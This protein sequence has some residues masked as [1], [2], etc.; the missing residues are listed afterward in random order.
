MPAASG[1]PPGAE[2]NA[3]GF[4]LRN[5]DTVVFY[6][7]SITEQNYYNQYVELYA[8]TRFPWMRIHFYGA[9]VG[10]DRVTGGGGG[11]VD[12]R[13]E[14]DVFSE[15]PT[16]VTVMLGMNDG[17]YRATTDEI[18]QT[19]VKGYEH[20]LDSIRQRAPGARLTLLGPS[21]YDD[22]TRPVTFPGGYNAVMQH[23]ADVDQSLADKYGAAFAN[24]NP[25]VAAAIRKADAM[26]PKL[27][28]LLLPDRVHPDPL[29]HWVMA[30]A[31]LK[32]WHAPA[33]VSD[34]T[35]DAHAGIVTRSRNASVSQV[36]QADGT[37]KWT[38]VE[39]ALPLPLTRS[40]A[41]TALLEDLT[42]IEQ[43]LNQETLRVTGLATGRYMLSIDGEVVDTFS[44]EALE[45]GINLAEYA[46]PMFH[47][48]QRV[49]WLVRDRDET[50][51]IHLR[52]RVRN[53][54]MGEQA[55]KLDVMQA[56]ENSLEDSIYDAATPKP[57]VF[58]LTP[59]AT[60]TT[61]STR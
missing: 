20:L 18:E 14:R 50:H 28:V 7:D 16:V 35:V 42:D 49:S 15:K 10:G 38:E 34:V 46:T 45:S 51:Y 12:Q 39:D 27:A 3:R 53:A 31:V 41:T 36:E 19:Y 37:L 54:D 56:F 58:R 25:P 23:F 60:G 52:M 22:V 30:E 48:A 26:D 43:Q 17:G 6:G 40:N 55:G 32:G 21:P 47:Q 11:P 57:H 61:Q 2:A 33:L 5:G 4:Y 1:A 24:L 8:A 29:A 9:G 59:V 13:L 44:P